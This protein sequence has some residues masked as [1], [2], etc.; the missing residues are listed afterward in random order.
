[1]EEPGLTLAFERVDKAKT[2]QV[3]PVWLS[4]RGPMDLQGEEE[5]GAEERRPERLR[6]VGGGPAPVGG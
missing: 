4:L 5:W 2:R 6:G 1:M 3:Q